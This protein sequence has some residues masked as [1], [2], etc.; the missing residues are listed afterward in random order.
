M[1]AEKQRVERLS[2][3]LHEAQQQ[4]TQQFVQQLAEN[5]QQNVT[6]KLAIHT[7]EH[8]GRPRTAFKVPHQPQMDGQPAA[9][10][11][12]FVDEGYGSD[13]YAK[14]QHERQQRENA[15]QVLAALQRHSNNRADSLRSTLSRHSTRIFESSQPAPPNSQILK[16]SR[17]ESL[18]L[19][20]ERTRCFKLQQNHLCTQKQSNQT[21]DDNLHYCPVADLIK[22]MV[23]TTHPYLPPRMPVQ[24]G[25]H[26][27][28][29]ALETSCP[30]ATLASMHLQKDILLQG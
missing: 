28:R 16:R 8:T 23:P 21:T 20:S 18:D 11:E 13:D 26:N 1:L 25:V 5:R 30:A 29:I 15:A 24:D 17:S 19:S 10:A 12:T 7:V 4:Y 22:A 6:A 2:R 3:P 9:L 27:K 14:A